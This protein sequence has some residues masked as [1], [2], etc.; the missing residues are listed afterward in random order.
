MRVHVVGE[1][2]SHCGTHF[3]DE[4]DHALCHLL[5]LAGRNL[6]HTNRFHHLII[7]VGWWHFEV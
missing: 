5:Q 4:F 7:S 2:C 1:I 6:T 3:F